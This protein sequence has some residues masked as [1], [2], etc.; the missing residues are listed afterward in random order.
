MHAYA[1]KQTH[2]NPTQ[3]QAHKHRNTPRAGH[4]A[5]VSETLDQ[6]DTVMEE[7]IEK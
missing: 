4:E 6:E 1:H 2:T 3:P 5:D 7:E